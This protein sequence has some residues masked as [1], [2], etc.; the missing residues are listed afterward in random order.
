MSG[1]CTA[2]TMP[3]V[4]LPF[5]T[6]CRV[7]CQVTDNYFIWYLSTC[8]QTGILYLQNCLLSTI[9][10][11][12][13]PPF[14][15]SG[16]DGWSGK[17]TTYCFISSCFSQFF[18][19][20]WSSGPPSE[21]LQGP[22]P[23]KARGWKTNTWEPSDF[24]SSSGR[25]KVFCETHQAVARVQLAAGRT[26]STARF[27]PLLW[28]HCDRSTTC[29]TSQQV[30]M[31]ERPRSRIYIPQTWIFIMLKVLGHPTP[32]LCRRIG[33]TWCFVFLSSL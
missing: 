10:C 28:Q 19:L 20:S 18:V 33:K 17:G 26:H 12:L 22:A 4:L 30:A 3:E 29:V 21:Q 31:A 14:S 11:W 6:L 15:L 16:G 13:C 2:S 9:L 1:V 8:S 25:S 32:H 7:H 23:G 27:R 24:L 5:P